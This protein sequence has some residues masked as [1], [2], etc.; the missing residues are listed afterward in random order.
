MISVTKDFNAVPAKLN[1]NANPLASAYQDLLLY[2]NKHKFKGSIYRNGSIASLKLI[3]KNK[4]GYCETMTE[5]GAELRVDHYRPKDKVK[6]DTTHT[7]G[8]YWL[9]YEWSNLILAC[10]KCNRAKSNKFPIS[11]TGTRCYTPISVTGTTTPDKSTY[12][13]THNSLTNE[14][15]LIVNPEVDKDLTDWFLFLPNGEMK[16]INNNPKIIETIKVCKLNREPLV[17]DRRKIVDGV[18]KKCEKYI[19]EYTINKDHNK[20]GTRINDI[21]DDL[22]E[23]TDQSNKYSRFCFFTYLKFD[24]FIA[25]KFAT[26]SQSLLKSIFNKHRKAKVGY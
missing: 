2:K 12:K 10:E 15:P 19:N 5:A 8:Y 7:T 14:Q 4:C 26:K 13:I 3:Y 17:L 22:Y 23:L 20:L 21:L 1:Y 11:L 9:S 6:E 16:P 18:Y 25:S 24:L